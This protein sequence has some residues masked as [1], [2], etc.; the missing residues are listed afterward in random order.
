MKIKIDSMIYIENP[1][2]EI[3]SFIEKELS[4]YEELGGE[5]KC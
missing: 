4:Y 1:S 2:K 3:K 5:I